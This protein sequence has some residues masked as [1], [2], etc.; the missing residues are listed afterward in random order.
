MS[1]V[2]YGCPLVVVELE[3]GMLFSWLFNLQ[4]PV[5]QMVITVPFFRKLE[6]SIEDKE[7]QLCETLEI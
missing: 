1:L 2:S 5:R 4:R 6:V 7:L 3:A